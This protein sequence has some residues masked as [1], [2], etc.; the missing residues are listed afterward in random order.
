MPKQSELCNILGISSPKT[1]RAH[2]KYLVDSEYLKEKE[3]RYILPEAEDIYFLIPLDTLR[4]LNDNCK[5][6]IIKLYIYLGQKYK[7]AAYY[8]EECIFTLEDLG[9]HIGKSVKNNSRAYE[10][11][12]N[13]L[14][15]LYNSGLID[16]CS[17]YDGSMQKKKLLAFN[18]EYTRNEK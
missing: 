18:F 9:N 13:A 5:E 3:D 15:F 1:Y 4:Y 6:H 8:Q 12:N 17:Y 11:L 2:L 16:Y 7:T 10:A 14:T